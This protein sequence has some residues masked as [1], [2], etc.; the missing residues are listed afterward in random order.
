MLP[1]R[2]PN[3]YRRRRT[4][5]RARGRGRCPSGAHLFL[6]RREG[7]WTASQRSSSSFHSTS[8]KSV[9][10]QKASTPSS[11]SFSWRASSRRRASRPGRR[12]LFVRHQDQEVAALGARRWAM[13]RTSAADRWRCMGEWYSSS[14]S[15]SMGLRPSARWRS[16]PCATASTKR[17]R[18]SIW[19]RL[20]AAPPGA[21]SAHDAAPPASRGIPRTRSR[22]TDRRS[23]QL[24]GVADVR[25]V[26]P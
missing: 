21:Q 14:V 12:V 25:L 8:G 11:I 26:V 15:S 16:A 9:I 19:R 22:A 6:G 2:S 7:W 23:R 5:G 20:N 4:R 1:P 3:R 18:S 17:V 13:A 10:R 24:H